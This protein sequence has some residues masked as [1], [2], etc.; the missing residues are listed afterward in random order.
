MNRFR[1]KFKN[2]D[3]APKNAPHF[4]HNKMF[5]PKKDFVTLID[6]LHLNFMQKSEKVISQS[7]E[8]GLT[9]G[10]TDGPSCIQRILRQSRGSKIRFSCLKV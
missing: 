10:R 3:F 9:D 8:N 1:E 2:V 6:L 4:V 5:S 7:S